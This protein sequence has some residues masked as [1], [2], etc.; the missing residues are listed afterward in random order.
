[1]ILLP[2]QTDTYPKPRHNFAFTLHF[3]RWMTA[4]V[5]I[6]DANITTAANGEVVIDGTTWAYFFLLLLA[7]FWSV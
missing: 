5:G 6:F 1:V 3:Y 4:F 2:N 7:L